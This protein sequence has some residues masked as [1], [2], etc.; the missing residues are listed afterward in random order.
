MEDFLRR[1]AVPDE[2]R[3]VIDAIVNR[4]EQA[5]IEA[6]GPG[7]FYARDA[8]RALSR[9][10]GAREDR[11]VEALL[12][13][14]YRRGVLAIEEET[15]EG[16]R[17]CVATFY[18]RLDVFAVTEPESYAALPREARRALDAWYFGAYLERLGKDAAPT[19][20]RVLPLAETLAF[21]DETA[22]PVWLNRC[23][24]RILAGN[25]GMPVDT[26]ISLRGGVNTL[27]H[28]GWSR[29]L[30]REEAKDVVRRADRAGLVHTVNP[31]S[32][33]NCC[34]DCCY[35]F[36]AQAAR[37]SA[38]VWPASPFVARFSESACIGCGNCASRCP[39]G[40]FT[41]RGDKAAFDAALCRGCGVCESTCPT[42]AI[43][44][45]GRDG[46]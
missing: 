3:G 19:A 31:H 44:L 43:T 37:R 41:L 24:C 9:V 29:P 40:A 16:T 10:D 22:E 38:A 27:S 12:T 34:S 7:G 30:T 33:C 21:L 6:L 5:L 2:A 8:R 36:R 32:I 1:F 11:D 39:F 18:D 15:G 35:L 28:R 25:C 45:A 26:C 42:G 20:D 23:D 4:Q 46:A 17:Y 14:A 13:N